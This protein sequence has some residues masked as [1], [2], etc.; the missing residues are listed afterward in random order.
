MLLE[1]KFGEKK[2]V[3]GLG[4]VARRG[5]KE[6]DVVAATGR[7]DSRVD[8]VSEKISC[9]RGVGTVPGGRRIR[10]ALGLDNLEERGIEELAEG[11]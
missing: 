5:G 8:I 9:W 11:R 6:V 2:Y 3:R 10:V 7:R 4:S 1:M